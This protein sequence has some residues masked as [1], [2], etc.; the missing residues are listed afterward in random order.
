MNPRSYLLCALLAASSACFAQPQDAC[1][2]GTYSVITSP[3][4]GSLS[5]LFDGFIVKAGAAAGPSAS[6]TCALHI[7]LHLPADQSLGVYKIDYR[8]FAKLT[9]RQYGDLSVAYALGPK[10]NG[11]NYRRRVKGAHDGDF[12]FSET[13]GAG[14]MKRV[15][16][17]EQA[18]M[19][20][21]MALDLQTND[22]PEPAMVALDSTDGTAR[23]LVFH[24]DYRKCAR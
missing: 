24:L 16:C 8:G 4:G 12:L 23:G 3:D 11:R 9:K 6:M 17:G 14:A 1:P 19:D 22:Q 7:P 15:G 20:V 5:I 18:S 13:L 21:T 10:S 2:N